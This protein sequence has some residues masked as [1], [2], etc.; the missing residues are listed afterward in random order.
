MELM[1][2]TRRAFYRWK[3]E[4]ERLAR[5]SELFRGTFWPLYVWRRW[6]NYRASSSDKAKFL[7]KVYLTTVIL[8]HF[9]AWN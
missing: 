7:R 4:S 6:T 9:R 5:V 1:R 3:V 2:G 8:R